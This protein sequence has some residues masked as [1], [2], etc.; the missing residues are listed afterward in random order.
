MSDGPGAPP[1]YRDG[2]AEAWQMLMGVGQ[3]AQRMPGRLAARDRAMRLTV[4]SGFLGAGKT[5]LLNRLLRAPHGR[6]LAVLVN[7][8]G[9][10]NIDSA[11]IERRDGDVVSL[12]NGCAC[13]SL[14]AGLTNVLIDLAH[15]ARPPDAIVL[16]ASGIAEPRGIAHVALANPAV[17]LDGILTLVDAANLEAQLADP[18]LR[19]TIERQITAADLLVLNKLDLVSSGQ[20]AALRARLAAIAPAHRLIEATQADVPIDIVLGLEHAASGPERDAGAAAEPARADMFR[21]WS[22]TSDALLDPGRLVAM[23]E[24]LPAGV[25]RAKGV[26]WL[27]DRPDRRTVLQMVGRRWSLTADRPWG[28]A[29]PRSELVVIATAGA[30]RAPDLGRGLEAC[31]A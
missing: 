25:L 23:I 18:A 30:V 12:T 13:C 9:A 6:R 20:S 27:A 10:L 15:A 8:F 16:E 7:D 4:I 31:R 21:S 26:L 24:R 5:T 14:A 2:L 19:P 29:A 22:V 17:R 3:A 11:L 28:E 1:G